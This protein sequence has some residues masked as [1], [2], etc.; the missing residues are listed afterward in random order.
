M[1]KEEVDN[2]VEGVEG[3]VEDADEFQMKSELP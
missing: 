3:E 1:D 2:R